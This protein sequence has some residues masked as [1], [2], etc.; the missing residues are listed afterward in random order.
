M[1]KSIYLLALAGLPCLGWKRLGGHFASGHIRPSYSGHIKPSYSGHIKR[2]VY[3]IDQFER[4]L[5]CSIT[6]PL[7]VLDFN[8]Y[9][10]EKCKIVQR[11]AVIET[12][13]KYSMHFS[14]ELDEKG[15]SCFRG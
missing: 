2:R 5:P 9:N 11:Q 14:N 7:A 13:T 10:A 8:L 3:L 12:Q 15:C 6:Q 1:K 4:C